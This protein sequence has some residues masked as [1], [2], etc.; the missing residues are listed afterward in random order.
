METAKRSSSGVDRPPEPPAKRRREVRDDALTSWADLSPELIGRVSRFLA[1]GNPDLMNFLQTVGPSTS[2]A[3]RKAYLVDND[4]YLDYCFDKDPS[5]NKASCW[6]ENN[7]VEW[8][9]RCQG[10]N[11]TDPNVHAVSFT[12]DDVATLALRSL[13]SHWSCYPD[14][15]HCSIEVCKS[16]RPFLSGNITN[17][18]M[19]L[20]V[21]STK[22]SPGASKEDVLSSITSEKPGK[23]G[24]LTLRLLSYL[25]FIF[26]SPALAIKQGLTHVL[27]HMVETGIVGI[28]DQ[29]HDGTGERKPLLFHAVV[30]RDAVGREKCFRSFEYL[31]SCQGINV[32]AEVA[33]G[34]M[35]VHECAMIDLV[36]VKTLKALLRHPHVDLN[37]KW[38]TH[39]FTP[40][41]LACARKDI[42]K[43]KALLECGA[44]PDI[45]IADGNRTIDLI[46]MRLSEASSEEER[47]RYEQ[48]CALLENASHSTLSGNT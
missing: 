26:T 17:I 21:G 39:G 25:Y 14:P 12:P 2:A 31:L 43:A 40:L 35:L 1:M 37:A 9:K 15:S 7:E 33:D 42:E 46:R 10:G 4:Y 3:V 30:G 27:K 23:D 6:L 34:R 45:V 36:S 48:L 24:K 44:D 8:K 29:F 28:N 5:G 41:L 18:P 47:Q 38:P 13:S 32:N 11:A 22:F 20:S 19:L 16:F